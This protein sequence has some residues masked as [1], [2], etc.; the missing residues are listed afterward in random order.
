MR[1]DVRCNILPNAIYQKIVSQSISFLCICI[2]K[3]SSNMINN[4][5]SNNKPIAIASRL[6]AVS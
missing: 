1:K 3:Y 6:S 4:N 5:S 2:V